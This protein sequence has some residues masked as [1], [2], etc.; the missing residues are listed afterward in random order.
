ME[1]RLL[2]V[3]R[4]PHIVQFVGVCFLRG[5]RLPVLLLEM[6]QT[7]LHDLLT[8]YKNI[9]IDVKCSMLIDTARGLVYLHNCYPPIIHR[10]LTA[11]NVLLDSGLTAKLADLG[12]VRIVN[13][14]PGQ[15]SATLTQ[16][17]GNMNYMPPEAMDAN[18]KASYG[19]P[20]DVFSFGIVALFTFT[21]EF[22][23]D[24]QPATYLD[25]ESRTLKARSEIDRRSRYVVMM[26]QALS[27]MLRLARL[28]LECLEYNPHLRP[29]AVDVLQILEEA[30]SIIPQNC[31][32]TKL[33]L[34]QDI[35]S[36]R[37]QSERLLAEKQSQVDALQQQLVE[38]QITGVVREDSLR[39]VIIVLL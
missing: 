32:Q 38:L 11:S 39:F 33:E 6:L 10:D 4:H 20:L 34:I 9:P 14:F 28:V 21:Q 26:Y 19:T 31:R 37:I 7:D 3:I 36:S 2:S 25:P 24:V 23:S 29:N 15:R 5:S 12:V 22:P 8:T 1:C 18:H 35:E 30:A 16:M 27:E 17:P 13:H